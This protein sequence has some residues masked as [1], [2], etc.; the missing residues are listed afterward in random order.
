MLFRSLEV[1]PKKQGTILVRLI[2]LSKAL[3]IIL[4]H[5]WFFNITFISPI[6]SINCLLFLLKRLKNLSPL[7]VFFV[8]VQL[9]SEISLINTPVRGEDIAQQM[10]SSQ[11]IEG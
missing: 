11:W 7:K 2:F 8:T 6:I 9:F 1:S 4:L 5:N 3:A 10:L